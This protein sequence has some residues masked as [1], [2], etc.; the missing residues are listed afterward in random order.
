MLVHRPDGP[1]GE[2]LILKSL[3]CEALVEALKFNTSI[4][5]IGLGHNK[6]TAAGA[7]SLGEAAKVN[8]ILTEMCL[9]RNPIGDPGAKAG[10]HRFMWCGKRAYGGDILHAARRWDRR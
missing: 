1:K 10:C 6:I 4:E 9:A 5:R 7:E 3:S 2:D 8:G